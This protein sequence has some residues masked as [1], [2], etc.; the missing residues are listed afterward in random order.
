MAFKPISILILISSC[1]GECD[2]EDKSTRRWITIFILLNVRDPIH[3]GLMNLVKLNGGFF[4]STSRKTCT[5]LNLACKIR[6]IYAKTIF[7][8]HC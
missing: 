2:S 3:D 1:R 7:I 8:I 4:F 6:M 5:L